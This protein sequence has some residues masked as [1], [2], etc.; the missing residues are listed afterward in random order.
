MTLQMQHDYE[1]YAESAVVH[2]TTHSTKTDPKMTH[3]TK[4]NALAVSQ[5]TTKISFKMFAYLCYFMSNSKRSNSTLHLIH[6]S[7]PVKI[8][9]LGKKIGQQSLAHLIIL[10]L[11]LSH[12]NS[13]TSK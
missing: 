2:C 7:D 3:K 10:F 11:L 12:T 9:C 8:R 4:R 6:P 13:L 1:K 5:H